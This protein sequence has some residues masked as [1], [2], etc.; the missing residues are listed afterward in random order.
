MPSVRWKSLNSL[1][2]RLDQVLSR[3]WNLQSETRTACRV[4][5]FAL[6]PNLCAHNDPPGI[7]E[8]QTLNLALCH[9]LQ[10]FAIKMLFCKGGPIDNDDIRGFSEMLSTLSSPVLATLMLSLHVHRAKDDPTIR[11]V[12]FSEMC[13]FDWAG[14]EAALAR[15]SLPGLRSLIVEGGGET[16]VLE[17]HIARVLP[18]LH[19]RRVI[20]LVPHSEN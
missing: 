17:D 7:F 8:H 2:T 11:R 5:V 3:D 20:Q 1:L 14:I 16:A 13:A 15:G 9:R 19:A 18:R 10:T 6:T 12:T 4:R